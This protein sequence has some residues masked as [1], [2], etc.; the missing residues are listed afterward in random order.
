M[1]PV[2]YFLLLAGIQSISALGGHGLVNP[3]SAC[4][5]RCENGG[6]C[7]FSFDNPQFHTCICLMGV[8]EGDRC[9][10]EVGAPRKPQYEQQPRQEPPPPPPPAPED[11]PADDY[12]RGSK[13]IENDEAVADDVGE[14]ASQ[15]SEMSTAAEEST[16]S[17][18]MKPGQDQQLSGIT[19]VIEMAAEETLKHHSIED[20]PESTSTAGPEDDD[21]W[22]HSVKRDDEDYE[23]PKVVDSNEDSELSPTVAATESGGVREFAAEEGE[24]GWMMMKRVD[25]NSSTVTISATVVALILIMRIW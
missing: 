18:A 7:A 16:V 22:D 15:R 13:E 6:M 14:T 2:A 4:N 10:Y 9:Q 11:D 20:E 3:Q 1:R 17:H 21:Y 23:L 24:E 25:E 8:Y 12:L 5:I 19:K